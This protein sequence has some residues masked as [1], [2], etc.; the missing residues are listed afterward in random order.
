MTDGGVH[1]GYYFIKPLGSRQTEPLDLDFS[2]HLAS[3][4]S[5]VLFAVGFCLVKS[6]FEIRAHKRNQILGQFFVRFFPSIRM[7]N[8]QANVILEDLRH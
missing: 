6:L 2:Y 3:L 5:V 8:V 4:Y 1:P 7:R